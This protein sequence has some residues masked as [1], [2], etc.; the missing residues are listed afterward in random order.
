MAQEEYG[1]EVKTFVCR[2]FYVD[3]GLASLPTAQETVQL[4]QSTQAALTTANLRLHKV[5]SNSV[6]VMEAF[7]TANLKHV[8]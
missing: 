6:E 8:Q 5:V 1:E 2:N 4:V 3:D 7:P